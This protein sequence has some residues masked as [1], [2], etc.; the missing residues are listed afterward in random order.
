[1]RSV[2]VLAVQQTNLATLYVATSNGL[3]DAELDYLDSCTEFSG[4]NIK[5]VH[6]H[7]AV[8]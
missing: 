7:G 5:V 3:L 8:Q 2:W 6:H 4:K 1:M